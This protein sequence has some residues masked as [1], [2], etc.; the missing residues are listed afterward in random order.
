MHARDLVR[1]LVE[2]GEQ[3]RRI[4]TAGQ[5]D[6]LAGITEQ[7]ER[8]VA[9][10]GDALA[11][12]T[13]ETDDDELQD[14]IVRLEQ[15]GRRNVALLESL[16]QEMARRLQSGKAERHAATSYEKSRSL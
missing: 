14:W 11:P 12:G 13:D 1:Q 16:K 6:E 10:L 15:Q 3:E 4:I 5:L 7:R 2:L 9:R 8:L